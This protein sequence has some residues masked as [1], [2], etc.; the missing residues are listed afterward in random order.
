M[1]FQLHILR[2]SFLQLH[3]S[4]KFQLQILFTLGETFASASIIEIWSTCTLLTFFCA[5]EC[6]PQR[7]VSFSCVFPVAYSPVQFPAVTF[8]LHSSCKFQ[9][10]ISLYLYKRGFYLYKRVFFLSKLCLFKNMPSQRAC[11]LHHHYLK[12]CVSWKASSQRTC[13]VHHR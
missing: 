2:R 5:C 8:Q 9:L 13:S 12:V 6:F 7:L 3:S 1:F 4:C 11:S 10:Q